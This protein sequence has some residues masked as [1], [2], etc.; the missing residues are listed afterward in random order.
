MRGVFGI[1]MLL[2]GIYLYNKE[3]RNDKVGIN[4]FNAIWKIQSNGFVYILLIGGT[5]LCLQELVRLIRFL[6]G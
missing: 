6:I 2:W 1:I 4:K 5:M 3:I